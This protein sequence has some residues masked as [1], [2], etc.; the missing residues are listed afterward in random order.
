MGKHKI[1]DCGPQC[2]A[3][4]AFAPIVGKWKLSIIYLIQ[5]K[6]RRFNLLL[7][8]LPG[9]STRILTKQL[10]EL[11][12]DG[13]VLRTIVREKPIAVEYSLTE[14]GAELLPIIDTLI[15]WRPLHS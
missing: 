12:E 9:I 13:V 14:R 7:S 15:A 11:E 10:K 8:L 5:R 4:H 1:Y 6:P 2:K 3:E